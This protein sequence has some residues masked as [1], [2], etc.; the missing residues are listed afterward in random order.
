MILVLVLLCLNCYLTQQAHP[1][2]SA[3]IV[4]VVE[5]K[6][7]QITYRVDEGNKRG[8][9]QTTVITAKDSSSAKKV[10]RTNNPKATIIS[11]SEF[12]QAILAA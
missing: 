5:L 2:C 11:V 12:R 7:W 3:G 9:P 1:K 6:Q 10:F 8:K 4:T